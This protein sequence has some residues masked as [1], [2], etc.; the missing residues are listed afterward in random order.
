MLTPL[1]QLHTAQDPDLF[2]LPIAS[3]ACFEYKTLYT[4]KKA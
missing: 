4:E 1:L 2:V 3:L